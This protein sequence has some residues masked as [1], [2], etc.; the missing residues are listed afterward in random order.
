[1]K[2]IKGD[3]VTITTG[4][5][6]GRTGAVLAVFPKENTIV[7]KDLNIFKKHLKS[8][9]GQKGGIIE[10][11]RPIL[12]SKVAV[13]CPSCKKLTRI[14]YQINK[15]SGKERICRKCKALLPSATK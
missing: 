6:K 7:V 13:V 1:M 5:D 12:A 9:Q 3:T 14:G 15:A 4:K 10:K 8:Q 11:E 2:I